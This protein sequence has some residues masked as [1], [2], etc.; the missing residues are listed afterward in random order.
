MCTNWLD[1]VSQYVCSVY[2]PDTNTNQHAILIYFVFFFVWAVYLNVLNGRG[3]FRCDCETFEL[4]LQCTIIVCVCDSWQMIHTWCLGEGI[5][6]QLKWI[7]INLNCRWVDP[8]ISFDT[9]RVHT[10]YAYAKRRGESTTNK[11]GTREWKERMLR[12]ANAPQTSS[13]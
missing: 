13:S 3:E 9:F 5:V 7:D 1:S 2:S 11:S 12:T 8:T 4:G 6:F 10:R